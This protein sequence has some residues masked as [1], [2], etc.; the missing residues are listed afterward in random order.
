M[1]TIPKVHCDHT[2]LDLMKPLEEIIRSWQ[3]KEGA[4]IPVL[5]ATQ[6]LFGYIPQEA[7]IKISEML[8]EPLSKVHGVITFY[9]YFSLKPRGKFMIRVCM[10]TACYVQGATEVLTALETQL[11]VK[12]GETTEDKLFTLDVGRCFGACG[13]APVLMVNDEVHQCVKAASVS[14]ILKTYAKRQPRQEGEAVK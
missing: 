14:K 6:S 1:A 8:N 5:Q 7:I 12:V 11:G 13:L 2:E 3:D 9:S 4:L 10:G